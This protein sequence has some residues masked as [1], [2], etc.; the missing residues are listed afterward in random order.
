MNASTLQAMKAASRWLLR[1]G[2]VPIYAK[3]L[4][5]QTLAGR[6][7]H[8]DQVPWNYGAI[9]AYAVQ[10]PTLPSV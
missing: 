10:I 3:S 5:T 2:K 6:S 8:H 9:A 4:R 1:T 7:T